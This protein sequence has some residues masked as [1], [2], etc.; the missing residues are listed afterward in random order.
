MN[1]SISTKLAVLVLL[2]VSTSLAR[3][4]VIV[5]GGAE[6]GLRHPFSIE[7][8]ESERLWGVE[9]NEGNRVFWMAENTKKAFTFFPSKITKRAKRAGDVAIDGKVS[10]ARAG[11]HG[12]HELA[13]AGSTIY[14][15]DTFNNRIRVYDGKTV[16]T[17][18]GRGGKGRFQGEGEPAKNAAFDGP[19]T[20]TLSADKQRLLV[21]DLGNR[22][23]RE[24]DLKTG[25]IR[26]V[27]G[28]GERGVPVDGKPALEQPLVAP[29][30]ACYGKD[31][32]I[33]IASREGHALRRVSPNG[34]IVTVVNKAGRKGYS[35]DGGPGATATLNGPKHL[36]VDPKGNI[37]IVDDNNHC[38]RVYKPGDGTIHLLAG[39][40]EKGGDRLGKGRHDTELNRPHGA[41]YDA[42][43]NLYVAD[44]FNHRI[45]KFTK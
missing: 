37:V 18:A 11:F 25:L 30:A 8:D 7:F 45:L 43:G 31:G 42:R 41:R 3:S 38:I 22:R 27:A 6:E 16:A 1:S 32:S 39:V 33:Y 2:A 28:N 10:D 35:G 5:V 26:T 13:I 36:C 20:V 34:R 19:H 23:V 15:A 29:R 24:V 14:L 12:M 40:P 17:F 9:Y 4:E 21:A 44:S